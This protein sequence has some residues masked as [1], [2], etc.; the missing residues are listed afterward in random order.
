MMKLFKILIP[1]FVLFFPSLIFAEDISD[2][3]IEGFSIGESMLD[4]FAEEE[5]INFQKIPYDDDTFYDLIA[6]PENLEIYD[7]L[8]FGVKKNDPDYSI[9][10]INAVLIYDNQIEYC[11]SKK[12]DIVSDIKE[13]F[14]KSVTI[15]EYKDSHNGDKTGNSIF[16][17]TDFNFE[18]GSNVRVMCLDLT[19]EFNQGP[20]HLRV[21]I[22][23]KEYGEWLNSKAYD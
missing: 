6:I 22:N 9:F 18:S 19:L 10:S 17:S 13:M 2:F 12:K 7:V 5:I 14:S 15:D 21:I 3:Q 4:S 11:L 23:S 16:Y 1:F 20:D 8:I